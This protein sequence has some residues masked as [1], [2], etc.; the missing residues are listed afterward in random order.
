[1]NEYQLTV[2]DAHGAVH[3]RTEWMTYQGRAEVIAVQFARLYGE[4]LVELVERRTTRKGVAYETLI[5]AEV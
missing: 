2:F 4:G 1:M 5:A 3:F